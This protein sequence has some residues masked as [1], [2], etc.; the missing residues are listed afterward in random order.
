MPDLIVPCPA[1]A[2]GLKLPD[3]ALLG[4]TA[5]CPKCQHRFVLQLPNPVTDPAPRPNES[6]RES[7]RVPVAPAPMV[8]TSARWVPDEEL[9]VLGEALQRTARPAVNAGGSASQRGTSENHDSTA[10]SGLPGIALS[11]PDIPASALARGRRKAIRRSFSRGQKIGFG[12]TALLAAGGLAGWWCLR[13]ATPQTAP[14]AASAAPNPGYEKEKQDRV[15]SNDAA[16]GLSPTNGE[17]IPLDHLPFTPH[18]LFHLHPDALWKSDAATSEFRALLSNLGLWLEAD[19]RRRTRFEPADI[20]ELTYALNFGPRMTDPDVAVVVRLREEHTESDLIKRFGGRMKPVPGSQVE[21]YEADD[22]SF[23]AVDRKTFVA[24]SMSMTDALAE[25]RD[26]EAIASPDLQ[27]LLDESDRLRHATLLMDV[28]LVDAHR[29]GIFLPAMLPLVNRFM[30]WLGEDIETASW[31][32]HL[33]PNLYMETLLLPTTESSPV[34]A[35]R[36]LQARLQNLPADMLA[37]VRRM[38]PSTNGS[39]QMIGRFPAM[40]QALSIGTTTHVGPRA[41]RAVTLLPAQAAANLAAASML[42]WNQSLVTNFDDDERVTSTDAV[43]IPDKLTDRLLLPVLVDFRRMPLQEAFGYLGDVIKTEV[44]IDGD[45]LKSA[46]FTQNM[47][48]TFNLGRV[49]VL[50]AIDAI[51]QKYAG[52]RDPLVLI[53]DEPAKRLLLTTK[54][55]AEAAGQTPFATKP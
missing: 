25:S 4:K 38:Q 21:V 1:C 12:V 53:V 17:P 41:T 37:A 46:G 32:L 40:L 7:G 13:E 8:G 54:S 55:A 27:P 15:A 6:R 51:L 5:R 33:S 35:Q 14:A 36:Q 29:E 10:Q 44:S 26:S 42:A 22:F 9:P 18:V 23:L 16:A 11:V 31:S 48:Q 52:E 30:L 47:E 34:K 2:A 28:R 20:S 24:A 39:R 3:A 49:P 19:I 43:A 50:T 45:A